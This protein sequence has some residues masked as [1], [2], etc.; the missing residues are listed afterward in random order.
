MIYH[1]DA[2]KYIYETPEILKA[3]LNDHREI[4]EICA[5]MMNGKMPD[6]ILLTGSGSSYNA[7]VG[8]AVFAKKLLGIRV[9]PVYPVTLIEDINILRDG[10]LVLG[11]SQQGTSTAVIN[12]LDTVRDRR[13]ATLAVTGEHDSEII[14][15]GDAHLYVECGYEDAGAT[16]KGYTVTLMTLILFF[17]MLAENVGKITS[18]QTEEYMKRLNAVTGNMAAVLEECRGW[19]EKTAVSLK[20]SKD[21][22]V[23]SSSDQ[24]AALLE[25]CLKFS[26][27]CRF[28]VRGY[29]AEEFMHGIYNAVT[30]DTD[31]LYLFPAGGY[32]RNRMAKLLKYYDRQGKHQ[33]GVNLPQEMADMDT[34]GRFSDCT[35]VNDPDFS[36]LEYMLP[37]QLLFVLT[38]R[39]RQINLNLPKDPEFH[40]YM[41]SKLQ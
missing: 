29:E 20:S 6:E 35:F 10:T 25:C 18:C 15:H 14:K 34:V 36:A 4:L 17:I 38:S 13:I 9:S 33:Y 27:T 39:E 7:A 30:D 40:K 26:E 2:L 1:G 23:I 41:G 11:I 37:L 16:T 12:A 22:M 5:R 28:P 3:I 24:K 32:E 19:C 8:A 21:M 31:F